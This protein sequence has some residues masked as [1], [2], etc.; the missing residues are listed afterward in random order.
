MSDKP[1]ILTVDDDTDV[2]QAISRATYDA[3][4]GSASASSARSPAS[5]HWIFCGG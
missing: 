1:I 4:S 5:K 3:G 2:L